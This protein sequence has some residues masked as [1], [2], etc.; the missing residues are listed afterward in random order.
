MAGGARRVGELDLGSRAQVGTQSTPTRNVLS[1]KLRS[2]EAMR[3]SWSDDRLDH[4]NEKVG[5]DRHSDGP[6]LPRSQRGLPLGRR[7]RSTGLRA[8][9]P[10]P[11]TSRPALRSRSTSAWNKSTSVSNRSTS[12]FERVERGISKHVERRFDEHGSAAGS[13][14]S[15]AGSARRAARQGA[16]DAC[17]G[18]ER[19]MA[20]VQPRCRRFAMVVGFSAR[21]RRDR[22]R[23]WLNSQGTRSAY[24]LPRRGLR[25]HR[26]AERLRRRDPRLLRPRVRH[27][28]PARAAHR[29]LRR[30]PQLRR[31]TSRWPSSAG[32]G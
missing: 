7:K 14:G 26:R 16:I 27:A 4:L 32:S 18:I 21:R 28:G 29:R 12:C 17:G 22:F 31:S 10:A 11:G 9:R 2:M 25:P 23:A 1:V 3:Q 30:A 5:R 8:T 19:A 20:P 13:R 24:R 15:Q 6:G